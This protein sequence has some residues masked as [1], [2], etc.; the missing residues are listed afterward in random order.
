MCDLRTATIML[1]LPAVVVRPL[2]FWRGPHHWIRG[3]AILSVYCPGRAPPA[4]RG[5]R[6]VVHAFRV[7]CA[8]SGKEGVKA[9][10]V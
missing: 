9:A 4:G 7:D 10:V 1:N 5:D 8:A 6:C 2:G 3:C